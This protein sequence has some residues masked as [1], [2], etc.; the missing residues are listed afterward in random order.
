MHVGLCV[1][2]CVGVFIRV[3]VRARVLRV[4]ACVVILAAAAA[5]AKVVV[6]VVAGCRYLGPTLAYG[7]DRHCGRLHERTCRA[8]GVF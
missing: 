7:F 5:A 3:S 6:M 4:R 1:L 8:E 2:R